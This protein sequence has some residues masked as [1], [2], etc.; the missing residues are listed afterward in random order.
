MS[1]EEEEG[2]G[3]RGERKRRS[4]SE[5]QDKEGKSEGGSGQ[6]KEGRRI[7]RKARRLWAAAVDSPPACKTVGSFPLV[8]LALGYDACTTVVHRLC[9]CHDSAYIYGYSFDSACCYHVTICCIVASELFQLQ[10]QIQ[11]AAVIIG[12]R[13]EAVSW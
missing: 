6:G 2:E 1:K 9:W 4:D 8:G 10:S 7:V 3:E 5:D 12:R 13:E 11:H